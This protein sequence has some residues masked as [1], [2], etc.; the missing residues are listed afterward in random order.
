MG[1]KG[2]APMTSVFPS[3]AVMRAHALASSD[4][5]RVGRKQ[6]S[7]GSCTAATG[8]ERKEREMC[9]FLWDRLPPPLLYR[10]GGA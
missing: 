4:V 1:A 7:Y 10:R 5:G 2:S 3:P 8:R 6:M 9:R